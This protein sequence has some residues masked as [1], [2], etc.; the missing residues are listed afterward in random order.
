MT[1]GR[2]FCA[3]IVMVGVCAATNV[4]VRAQSPDQ[5][6]VK[7]SDPSRPGTVVVELFNGGITVRGVNR[8]D[9]LI[10]RRGDATPRRV[11][12]ADPTATTGL[13][14]LS[15][16]GGYEVE[17]ERN[18]IK[19]NSAGPWSNASFDIQVPLKTNLRLN[20]VNGGEG[21]ITDVEG[22]VEV[23]NVNGA[24]T[25]T[26]VGGAIVANTMNGKVQA[27][28]TKVTPDKPMSFT[29]FNGVVDV[30]LPASVKANFKLRSDQGEVWSGFDLQTRPG[31]APSPQPTNRP[32]GR[33]RIEVNNAIYGAV[34][35]GG[36]EIELRTFNGSV[37]LRKG[38][39][40]K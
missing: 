16:S 21:V 35:G 29:S 15:S 10:D 25:L 1:A 11:R 12:P 27:T 37:F 34:N 31:P 38:Q 13:R 40:L 3:L 28:M 8:S 22:D 18:T 7:F 6:T 19:I 24:V 23:S 14:R 2:T 20:T 26:N 33:Y 9:V 36:A 4:P 5:A 17:E 32:G 39:D 30:T